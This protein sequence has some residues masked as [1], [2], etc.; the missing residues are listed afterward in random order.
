MMG[1]QLSTLTTDETPIVFYPFVLDKT[2]R[3]KLLRF[4]QALMHLPPVHL[5]VDHHFIDGFYMRVMFIPAGVAVVG[6]VHM[7]KCITKVL[8]GSILISD[9]LSETRVDAPFTAAVP[10]GEKKAVYALTNTIWTDCYLNEDNERDV[11]V[12][13]ARLIARDHNDYL[14]RTSTANQLES[15]K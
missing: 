5:H 9:G 13:E 11:E 4:E 12:L 6:H 14:L 1:G 10:A 7:Q 8:Q 15:F 3:E 2:A